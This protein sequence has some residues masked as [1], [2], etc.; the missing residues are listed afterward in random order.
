MVVI[1][2]RITSYSSQDHDG[3]LVVIAVRITS[4]F[5]KDHIGGVFYHVGG[6]FYHIGGVCDQRMITVGKLS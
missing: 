3:G 4:H 2:I 5:V 6:V 1:S